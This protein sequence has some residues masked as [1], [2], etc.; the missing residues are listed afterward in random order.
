MAKFVAH[1]PVVPFCH[2]PMAKRVYIETYGCQMNVAD[3]EVIGGILNKEGYSF[4][5]ELNE[6]DIILVNTCAVRDNAEQRIYG[7]LGLFGRQ[8]KGRPG[9]V[10]GLLGCMAE[11]LRMQLVEE[12]R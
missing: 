12:E 9:V 7:R 2:S 6:A 4:T 5:K 11:R 10:V 1:F 8:K 3:S